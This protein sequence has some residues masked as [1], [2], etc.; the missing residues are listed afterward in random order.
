MPA[1][2]KNLLAPD[3]K[4]PRWFTLAVII[5]VCVTGWFY[6][7][8]ALRHGDHVNAAIDL[9]LASEC[10]HFYKGD[11]RAMEKAGR[12]THAYDLNDQRVYM[13][14]A[15]GMRETGWQM[16]VTR[17]RMPMFMWTLALAADGK[18]RSASDYEGLER[19][20]IKFFPVAR[21]FNIGLSALLLVAM[22]FA[23]RRWLGN[24]LGLCFTL[25]SAFQLFVLKSPYVQP[26]V[27]QTAIITVSVAWIVHALHEPSWKSGLAAGL[28]LCLWH[29]TKANALVALGLMGAVMGLKLLFAGAARERT[30]IIVAGLATLAAYMLPMS[31][32][33]YNSWKLFGDPFYNVQSKFYMWATDVDNKHGLQRM[34]LDRDLSPVDKDGDGKIDR[35][36]ELPSAGKYWREHS[37]ESIKKRLLRGIDSMF[38]NA[39]ELYTALHWFQMLWAGILVWA[40]ARRWDDAVSAAWQWKWEILYV[41]GLLTVF[42]YLF[43]W[44]TPL[45]VGPRLLNS[46]SLIPIFFCMAGARALLRHDTIRIGGV[47]CSTE[48]VLVM[49]FLATWLAVTALQLPPDLAD[50]YF[51]G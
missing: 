6:V 26:E 8:A 36:E 2:L 33:L 22:F 48:K 30:A 11:K 28:L 4:A 49:A 14:Y 13:N 38:F 46:I 41:A 20:Y 3:S 34:G 5:M 16:F 44:F 15:M 1:F 42:V 19:E 7:Q 17:M 25:V 47:E 45:K 10:A 24:W 32:Y 31:P 37:W 43:G 27:M 29:L 9:A 12:P 39:F 35:P 23:L 21:A 51:A 40:V 50:G 18:E